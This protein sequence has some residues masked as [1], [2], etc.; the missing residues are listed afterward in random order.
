SV[1]NWDL[2]APSAAAMSDDGPETRELFDEFLSVAPGPRVKGM[3]YYRAARTIMGLAEKS[4]YRVR[5][6]R[7]LLDQQ[8][9][10]RKRSK[11]NK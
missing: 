2:P 10:R 6:F 11:K 1:D 4:G 5:E 9:R 7:K 8:P 3:V